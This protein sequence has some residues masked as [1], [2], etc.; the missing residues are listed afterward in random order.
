MVR[1]VTPSP[2]LRWPREDPVFEGV[3]LRAFDDD[4]V[5]MV[6]DLATDPYVPQTGTLPLHA[7]RDEALAYL[8][9]QRGRLAEGVGYSFCVADRTSDTAL[10]QAGLWLGPLAQGRA[11]AGYAVAPRSRGQ[12]VAGQALTALTSFAWTIRGLHRVELYVEPWNTASL[13]TA[14]GAGYEPEG[15]LQ[16][17]QEIGGRR[18]DMLLLAALHPVRPAAR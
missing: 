9:R 2:E 5:E 17:H 11:T 14:E 8:A 4:D 3:R 6:M 7:T 13:R 10:G 1:S 12:H 15:L 16:S 18:V